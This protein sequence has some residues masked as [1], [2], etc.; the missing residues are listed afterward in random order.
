MGKLNEIK[1]KIEISL[2][3]KFAPISLEGVKKK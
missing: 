2:K 1:D 3:K